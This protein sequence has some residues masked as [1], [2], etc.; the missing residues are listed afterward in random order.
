[1]FLFG[2]AAVVGDT[3]PFFKQER[4]TF[5]LDGNDR[6]DSI[7][8]KGGEI[9]IDVTSSF[10]HTGLLTISSPQ[11]LDM[12]RDTFSTVIEISDLSGSFVDQQIFL[13]DGYNLISRV[14]NDTNYIQIN[15][16]LD[17]I[18]SGNIINPDDQ[19]EILTNFLDL[20]FYSV[21]GF[22]DSR[23]LITESG[24]FEIPLYSENPDLA[25]LI[26]ADPQ[27]YIY[28][29][30]SV[31]IPVEVEIN[32]MTATSSIDGSTLDLV[33][34]EGH[35]FQILASGNRPDGRKGRYRY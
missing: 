32:Q 23:D 30:N 28:I 16:R 5:E 9:V 25:N 1:M 3:V 26:F 12:N 33:I 6:V 18:N 31:G 27:L 10:E 34:T 22:I 14:E 35:P 21:F 7:L 15:F 29:S 4:F 20:D 17:L 2:W 19:C 13:S 8:I 24:T 11:I